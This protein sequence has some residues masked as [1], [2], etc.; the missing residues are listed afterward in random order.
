MNPEATNCDLT[1]TIEPKC[2]V[3]GEGMSVNWLDGKPYD[4]CP[5]HGEPET[6]QA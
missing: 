1:G 4:Y 3:C 5:E 2:P 6:T